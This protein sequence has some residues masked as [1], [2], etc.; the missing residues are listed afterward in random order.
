MAT[1]LI[2]FKRLFW[3]KH[4][5]KHLQSIKFLNKIDS[6]LQAFQVFYRFEFNAKM[7]SLTVLILTGSFVTLKWRGRRIWGGG[8]PEERGR[9]RNLV[10]LFC[11]YAWERR[12]DVVRWIV[13]GRASDFF[14]SIKS[15]ESGSWEGPALFFFF[16]MKSRAILPFNES[17]ALVHFS[18]CSC[19]KFSPWKHD[20]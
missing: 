8:Q 2:L 16:L 10:F 20:S 18:Y 9:G 15:G 13:R 11:Y 6:K 12:G 3:F 5:I 19:K 1:S 14:F 4:F 7:R 17:T